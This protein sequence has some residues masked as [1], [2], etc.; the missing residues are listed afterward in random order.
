L[1]G[2]KKKKTVVKKNK[3]RLKIIKKN[4]INTAILLVSMVLIFFVAR[5][6]I[7]LIM[8]PAQIVMIERG[9]VTSEEH[10]TGYIIREE[11]VLDT[12]E[13]SRVVP[14]RTEGER[15][16]RGEVVFRHNNN[17]E[18]ALRARINELD[19]EIQRAIGGEINIDSPEIRTLERQIENRVVSLRDRNNIQ[20]IQEYINEINRYVTR[21]A[22]IAGEL[23]PADSHI[24]ELVAQRT[25]Y[26]NQIHEGS[27]YVVAVRG[28]VLSYR[29]DMLE[30]VLTLERLDELSGRELEELNLRVGQ[31]IPSNENT[32][33]IVNNFATY[34]ATNV[35]SED[36]RE[37]SVGQRI[38]LRLPIGEVVRGTIHTIREDEDGSMFVVFRITERVEDLIEYRKINLDIIWWEFEGLK[39]PRSAIVFEGELAYVVRNRGGILDRILVKILRESENYF[40]VDN[41]STEELRDMDFTTDQINNRRIIS[42]F[43]ELVLRPDLSELQ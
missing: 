9:F 40:I 4:A 36:A 18:E 1:P 19:I 42:M 11:V 2:Q 31:R 39:V 17:E 12:G 13:G 25:A 26:E 21:K 22:Q 35:R 29:I 27:E 28:G 3:R 15:V 38:R 30:D 23:S 34:I 7:R 43:D 5:G 41:F 33:K 24:R 20:E 8:N 37:A 10:V 16:A 32:G 14:I 6:V